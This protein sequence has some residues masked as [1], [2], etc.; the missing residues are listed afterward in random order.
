MD[1]TEHRRVPGL[2]PLLLAAMLMNA[3]SIAG[4][5]SSPL[6]S[7]GPTMDQIYRERTGEADRNRV[8]ERLPLRPPSE[9]SPGPIREAAM[10]QIERRFTRLPNPDLIMVVFPHLAGGK[11]PVPG[12]V[13]AFPMYER[14]EYLLPGEAPAASSRSASNLQREASTP[15]GAAPDSAAAR[16]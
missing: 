16:R 11:Y 4:P 5:R 6:P 13:T 7:E 15:D 9:Y 3:C 2:V 12:Y 10:R 8:R 14:V 1:W